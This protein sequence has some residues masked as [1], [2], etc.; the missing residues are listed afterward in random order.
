MS[1]AINSLGCSF[2][3]EASTNIYCFFSVFRE[4]RRLR[5]SVEQ[6]MILA[7]FSYLNLFMVL[8]IDLILGLHHFCT[9]VEVL[10]LLCLLIPVFSLSCMARPTKNSVMKRH[11][12]STKYKDVLAAMDHAVFILKSNLLKV[13]VASFC[14]YLVRILFLY[15][16]IDTFHSRYPQAYIT[17]F[18]DKQGLKNFSEQ[19]TYLLYGNWV[20]LRQ[21]YT[22]WDETLQ[23]E[24][25]FNFCLLMCV[26]SFLAI[27][28]ES[29]KATLFYKFTQ[30]MIFRWILGLQI[31]F[32]IV[33]YCLSVGVF[34]GKDSRHY[35]PSY[36]VWLSGLAALIILAII[37]EVT[38][39][40]V[41]ALYD[42]DHNRLSI[43]YST[44]LGMWSP[45]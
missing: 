45:R 8:F 31:L 33:Y 7:L 36:R 5:E 39:K 19:L 20:S 44:K 42:R 1:A 41:R 10:Y 11:V 16:A 9:Q 24:H 34:Q 40:K 13:V 3:F 21:D 26:L 43:F 4:A 22:Y 35:Y 15:E 28:L 2:V 12:L 27:G 25:K 14:I 6:A 17:A 18:E 38:K 32:I 29:P 30:N 23:L 37:E